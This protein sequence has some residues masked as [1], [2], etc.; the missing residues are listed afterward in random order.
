[1]KRNRSNEEQQ[2]EA[3]T[4]A[5]PTTAAP[6]PTPSTRKGGEKFIHP[7]KVSLHST[8]FAYSEI[9]EGV[10]DKIRQSL[11]N[12]ASSEPLKKK[13]GP[14]EVTLEPHYQ[15]QAKAW[16]KFYVHTQNS[17]F[18][19]K[20]YVCQAFPPLYEA[21]TQKIVGLGDSTDPTRVQPL[22]LL[23]CGCG[24]GSVLLPLMKFGRGRRY[25]KW[26]TE[27]RIEG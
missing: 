9:E 11:G 24:S 25:P 12:E 19:M 13:A 27:P 26:R 4:V 2:G 7:Q 23:E 16:E 17:F 18:P 14:K 21:L 15:S 20:N 3:N 5:S 10:K 1:M 22:V 8:D 6:A